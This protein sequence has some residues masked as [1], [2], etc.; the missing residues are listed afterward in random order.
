MSASFEAI[1]MHWPVQRTI[2]KEVEWHEHLERIWY[3][4]RGCCVWSSRVLWDR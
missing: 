4:G 2:L 1:C 3:G